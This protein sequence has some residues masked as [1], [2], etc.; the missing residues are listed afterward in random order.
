MSLTLGIAGSPSNN[1]CY[2][3]KFYFWYK[4]QRQK[5]IGKYVLMFSA[6]LCMSIGDIADFA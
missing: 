5:T 1:V 3:T 2:T 4:M 6:T